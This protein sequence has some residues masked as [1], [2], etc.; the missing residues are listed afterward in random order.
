MY[1]FNYSVFS[2]K[3]LVGGYSTFYKE[4]KRTKTLICIAIKGKK[5]D[6]FK[7]NIMGW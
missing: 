2:S 1:K 5:T 4:I 3:C 6:Y 7:T